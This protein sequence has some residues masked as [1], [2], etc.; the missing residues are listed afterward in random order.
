M[1]RKLAITVAYAAPGVEATVVLTVPAGA[2]VAQAVV[3]SGLRERFALAEETIG[4]A[5]YGQRAD[6]D[7]PLAD[8][9]R[10]ELTRPLIADAKQIRRA[11]AA[12]KPLPKTAL[13]K[14]KA[15]G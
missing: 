10:I 9:D 1:T 3:A 11:R 4:Y 5:I 15:G 14:T 13:R 12:G 8:G 2:T 7:T 6:A